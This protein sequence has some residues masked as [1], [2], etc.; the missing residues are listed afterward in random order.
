MADPRLFV[1]QVVMVQEEKWFAPGTNGPPTRSERQYY[2][3]SSLMAA[4][5]AQA[6]YEKAC[7]SLRGL[8][9]ANCDGPGDRTEYF[10][11]GLHQLEELTARLG[12]L[13]EAVQDSYGLNLG[14]FDS[15]DVDV[16]GVP[17]VR[18]REELEVF[19]RPPGAAKGGHQ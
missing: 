14:I 13:T 12:D 19:Q 10:A 4:P 6:A 16:A 1:V 2:L 15:A 18:G 5:D 8:S 17:R 7:A 3:E 9:D 11:L